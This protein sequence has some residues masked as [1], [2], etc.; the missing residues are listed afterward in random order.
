MA[1]MYRAVQLPG[2]VS[3]HLFDEEF[4]LVT[5]V[6][7]GTRRRASDYVF[8]DWGSEF[9]LDHATAF[10]EHVN[11]GLSLDVGAIGLDYMLSTPSSGYCP[12]RIAK[13]HIRRGRLRMPARARNFVYPV[14]MVYPETRDEDA[15]E[16]ILN[17]LRHE[18]ARLRRLSS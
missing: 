16:P 4:V 17:A 15:F 1:I 5:S 3:E 7:A 11:P 2:L 6:K 8:F 12:L 9:G 13:K 18:S 10:P 14:Y